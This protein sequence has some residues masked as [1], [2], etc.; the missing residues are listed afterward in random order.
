MRKETPRLLS[1]AAG[2]MEMT[3]SKV[4]KTEREH[5]SVVLGAGNQGLDES[6]SMSLIPMERLHPNS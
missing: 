3:S 6:G 4:G 2:R 5:K 1:G